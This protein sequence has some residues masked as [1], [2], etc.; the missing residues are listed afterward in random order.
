MN[1]MHLHTHHMTSILNLTIG[2]WHWRFLFK[3][4]SL[5]IGL[6]LKLIRSALVF[7]RIEFF[8][9]RRNP[10]SYRKLSPNAPTV[11]EGPKRYWITGVISVFVL[12]HFGKFPTIRLQ[13][14]WN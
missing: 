6:L 5:F 10:A 1:V 4:E 13:F 9:V 2:R 8:S 12:A 11:C 3:R 7:S 14:H